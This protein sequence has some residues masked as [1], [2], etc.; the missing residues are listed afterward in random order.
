M[1]PSS[2]QD[3]CHGPSLLHVNHKRGTLPALSPPTARGAQPPVAHTRSAQSPVARA[4]GFWPPIACVSTPPSESLGKCTGSFLRRSSPP[5]LALPTMVP[6]FSCGPR[7]PPRFP[8]PWCSTPQP[9][10]DGSHPW[11]T[12]PYSLRVSP[13]QLTLVPFLE[14]TSRA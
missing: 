13:T 14:L 10:A 8:L 12:A 2:L 5:A 4:C 6:C 11:H 7:C 3:D 9:I 1:P